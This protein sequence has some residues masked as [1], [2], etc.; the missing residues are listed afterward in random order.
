MAQSRQL[1]LADRACQW[2]GGPVVGQHR[3][4]QTCSTLCR[5]RWRQ[6]RALFSLAAPP[7]SYEWWSREYDRLDRL[8]QGDRD[9]LRA[10]AG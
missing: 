3:D 2:C 1:K 7:V 9:R 5:R 6:V 4:R 10:V 8:I